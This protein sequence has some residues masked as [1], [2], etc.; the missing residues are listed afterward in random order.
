M[1]SALFIALNV[2]D[3]MEVTKYYSSYEI[4]FDAYPNEPQ[5]LYRN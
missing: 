1:L 3:F 5:K 2:L 4:M